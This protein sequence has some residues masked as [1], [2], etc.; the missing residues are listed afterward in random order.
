MGWIV[1]GLS[2]F[3]TNISSEHFIGLAGSGSSRGLVVGQ[4][5]LMA[6]FI[7]FLLGW[8][9]S[10]IYL[11]SGVTTMPEFLGNRFDLK[12]RKLQKFQ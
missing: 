1:V 2:I 12:T 6:I 10:P 3:A 7:L 4:F 9:L 8:I 11:K 5:E